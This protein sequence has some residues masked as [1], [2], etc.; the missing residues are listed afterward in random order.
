MPTATRKKPPAVVQ[1]H[2]YY[3][4]TVFGWGTGPTRDAAIKV[5]LE[6]TDN[7]DR[8]KGIPVWSIRVEVPQA[9]AYD[10][11]FYR[12]SGVP[13][14]AG[15]DEVGTYTLKGHKRDVVRLGDAE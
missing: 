1:D 8:K 9:S 11:D 12:P 14:T 15:S 2:H 5:C 13:M 3:A 6:W 10:I 7:Y 4:S